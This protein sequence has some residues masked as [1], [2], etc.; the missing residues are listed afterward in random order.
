MPETLGDWGK[1]GA[2]LQEAQ[3]DLAN[4]GPREVAPYEVACAA[5][6]HP[7]LVFPFRSGSVNTIACLNLVM[8][9]RGG[10]TRLPVCVIWV[11]VIWLHG[12]HFAP[13]QAP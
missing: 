1:I 12:P 7:W 4:S 3:V 2:C 9:D 11:C 5:P 10:K 13:R 6:N 8:K